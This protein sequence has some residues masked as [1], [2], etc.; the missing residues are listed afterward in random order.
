M[1]VKQAGIADAMRAALS[2]AKPAATYA[3]TAGAAGANQVAEILGRILGLSPK[4]PSL[5]GRIATPFKNAKRVI[6]S[7]RGAGI[8]VGELAKAN[9][10]L[11][12]ELAGTVGLAGGTS[13]GVA[14]LLTNKSAAFAEGFID[15]C[16]CMRVS[17]SALVKAAQAV[18]PM[19]A[20]AARRKGIAANAENRRREAFMNPDTTQDVSG[21]LGDMVQTGRGLPAL[22]ELLNRGMLNMERRWANLTG[23]EENFKAKLRQQRIADSMARNNY[24]AAA[25]AD[26]QN[27]ETVAKDTA[28]LAQGKLPGA[29]QS[30]PYNPYPYAAAMFGATSP[31]QPQTLP[32]PASM[33]A[34]PAPTP[35][36]KPMAPAAPAKPVMPPAP[37]APA[38]PMMPP[39]P[40]PMQPVKP[41]VPPMGTRRNAPPPVAVMPW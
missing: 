9:P 1:T 23:N 32:P 30:Q 24:A 18:D 21:Y 41:L 5:G 7:G 20:E 3:G 11:V 35:T 29:Q 34:A 28:T 16:M 26:W 27:S 8:G 38:K 37:A 40:K 33:P 39:A 17:P 36:P 2:A 12:G 14:G 22:G 6:Q 13:A 19:A 31:W 25:N 10:R 4:G 15:A